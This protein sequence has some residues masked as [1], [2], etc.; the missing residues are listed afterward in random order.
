M[1]TSKLTLREFFK[2][3]I[4]EADEADFQNKLQQ[5]FKQNYKTFV[6]ALGKF[7]Q[8]EK[9]REFVK[10]TDPQKSNVV[11]AAIAVTKLIPTQNE[12]DIT[13]SLQFPLTKPDAAA[14]A[15]KGGA[16]KVA[17]PIIVFN[18]KYIV[19]GH[20]RWSQL[21]AIN[22]DAKI[23]AYN[24]TN[25]DIKTPADALKLTQIAIVGAGARKLPIATVGQGTNLLKM[26]S[27]GV[28]DYV[29]K[30]IVDEV[31][32]VF[33]DKKQ[34]DTK[35]A[36]ADYIWENCSKMQTTSQPIPNASPRNI[37]PQADMGI[38]GDVGI[39]RT[40]QKL[41]Q[42]VPKLTENKLRSIVR[43]FIKKELN[44]K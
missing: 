23:V 41:Q 28:K 32:E 16:V 21:Y 13:K 9:F 19:D 44:K 15:L 1:K 5:I 20:H 31:V 14:Y 4:N 38:Q 17:S 39:K 2:D 3:E 26:D 42:G 10:N 37:M 11:L 27:E 12:I 22:K 43:D 35:E 29:I 7:V 34:L 25:P 30:T 8:D 18:G 33:K 24:V 40:V 36:I 6:P